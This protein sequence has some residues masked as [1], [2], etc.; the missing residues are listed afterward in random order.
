[1]HGE[2][3]LTLEIFWRHQDNQHKAQISSTLLMFEVTVQLC[4]VNK[5]KV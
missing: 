2:A 1:M 3:N 4:S 5:Y